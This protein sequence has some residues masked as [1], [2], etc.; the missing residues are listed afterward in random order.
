VEPTVKLSYAVEG[1]PGS[2]FLVL[3][4]SLGT[5]TTLFEPQEGVLAPHFRM[6][7]HDHPGHG[8][9]RPPEEPVSVESIALGVL[10]VLDAL[11]VERASFCGVSLGGMVC[12]WLGANAPERVDRLVLASTGAK[13]G[14]REGF[15]E[16]AKLVRDEG[17]AAVVDGVRERWF[18]P[19]FRDSPAAVRILE[20]LAAVEPE[21]YAS[22]CEA[23]GD[24]DLRADL[25]RI[26]APTLVVA[27][28]EDPLVTPEVLETLLDGIPDSHLAE[29]PG[30]AHLAN[31]E[32]PEAFDAAVIGHL[33]GS[34]R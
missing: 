22:C 1:I 24:F 31:V 15:Y 17:T 21:A 33:E 16:R 27:G 18:T 26:A 14:T 20:E 4:P 28:I 13:L 9:S 10:G 2:P 30:A 19:A 5:T 6:V 29:I 25:G 12:M 32:Q 23:A 11:N 7:R 34:A 3:S 8:H